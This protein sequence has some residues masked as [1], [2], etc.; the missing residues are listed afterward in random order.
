M[1]VLISILALLIAYLLGS[2]P[3][4][5]IIGKTRRN[6]D[7]RKVGSRNMGAMNTFY[8]VGF[9]WGMLVLALDIIK[10]MLAVMVARWL[11]APQ[12]IDLA[13]G[14]MAIIGHNLP[15]FLKFKGG[16]G[17]ATLIGVLVIIMP[18]W[19]IPV[20]VA[21]FGLLMLITR[22]PTLSYGVALLCFPFLAAFVYHNTAYIIFSVLMLLIPFGRYIPRIIE[23]RKKATG[24]W[25]QVAMR[26]N[27]KERL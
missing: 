26:K 16:K 27:L 20:Y 22:F 10:G 1:D 5:F 12:Y 13:C 6:V 2:L 7:I 3:S 17:G 24:G 11:E 4:A 18:L 8:N 19:G 25:K 21:I 15:V 9:W 23:M 14:A